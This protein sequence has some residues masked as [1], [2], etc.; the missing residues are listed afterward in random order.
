M[1]GDGLVHTACVCAGCPRK[2]WGAGYH[3]ILHTSYTLSVDSPFIIAVLAK[4]L[5]SKINCHYDHIICAHTLALFMPCRWPRDL[6]TMVTTHTWKVCT[7]P[8]P[9]LHRAWEQFITFSLIF[10]PSVNLTH[11]INQNAI[12]CGLS[13]SLV[14]F[15]CQIRWIKKFWRSKRGRACFLEDMVYTISQL[16][17]IS[18]RKI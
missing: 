10:A 12:I 11:A 6:V 5:S 3:Y 15:F 4:C 14:C 16:W 18:S 2:M 9:H 1:R 13:Y 17:Y 7:R 8:S